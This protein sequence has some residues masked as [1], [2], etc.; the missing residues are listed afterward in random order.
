MKKILFLSLGAGK[1]NTENDE[2]GYDETTYTIY[3]PEN[4]VNKEYRSNFVAEPIIYTFKP[5][6][7]FVLGTVKSI[8]HKLYASLITDD[9]NDKSYLENVSYKELLEI[10]RDNT[11]G[12]G[13]SDAEIKKIQTTVSKIFG[14]L[15]QPGKCKKLNGKPLKINILIT[16][17]GIN[18]AELKENYSIIK[19]IEDHIEKDEDY[20][21][22][23][24]ITLSFRSLPIYNLIIFNYIT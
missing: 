18:E 17:Y 2:A 13:T 3:D 14:E 10:A 7:I 23:F 8:W 6:E 15:N 12:H 24:D 11:L 19:G 20:K 1:I 22:A 9:N 5:D 16:K 21:V 4:K